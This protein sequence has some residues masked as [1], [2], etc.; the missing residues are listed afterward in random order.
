MNTKPLL[1][2]LLLPLALTVVA[3]PPVED[4][5]I[6]RDQLEA[7]FVFEGQEYQSQMAFGQAG[8]RCGTPHHDEMDLEAIEAQMEM[9]GTHPRFGALAANVTGGVISVYFH[10][11]TSSSGAGNIPTSAINAQMNVLNNAY[12]STGWSF[13]LVNVLTHASDTCYTM[14][15]GSTA[16]KNCKAAYRQGSADDLNLYAANIGGGLLGWATFPSS[17]H[18]RASHGR[19]RPPQLLAPGRDC[20]S[21]QRGRHRDARGRPLDGALPHVPGRLRP[22]DDGRGR[23]CRYPGREERR[24]R[25]P[26]GTRHLPV[27]RGP[28]P[29]QELHGLHG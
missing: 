24:L 2:A 13:N 23:G 21:L 25:L 1:A 22:Q 12:A 15:Y 19:R 18:V 27:D 26:D 20:G 17:Y 28:R 3:A 5:D 16:E 4:R 14:G 8:K 29:D 6:D 7:P 9:A 11:I 10:V